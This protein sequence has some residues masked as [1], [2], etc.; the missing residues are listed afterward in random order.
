MSFKS[1][2]TLPILAIFVIAI[3]IVVGTTFAYFTSTAEFENRFQT[4]PYQTQVTETFTSPDNWL[5]GEETEKK[6]F[7]KNTGEVEVALRVSYSEKWI[8]ANGNELSGKQIL[9]DNSGDSEINAAII[10]F[11]NESKWIKNNGYYYYYK[12]LNANESAESFIKAVEFNKLIAST[13]TCT[14]SNN[15]KKQVCETSKDGYDGATYTLTI[16]VE[17]I[18]ANAYKSVWTSDVN[19][20]GVV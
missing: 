19:I 14:T 4:K 6:V 2:K 18:Q 7:V 13:V 17:T 12:V 9:H 3:S 1:K 20:E 10:K 11:D 5:P 16:Y 15:G 8:N